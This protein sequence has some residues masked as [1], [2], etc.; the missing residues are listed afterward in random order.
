M[1]DRIMEMERLIGEI[2]SHNYSYYTLDNPT[3]SDAEYDRLY[4]RLTE[5]ERDTG[6]VLPNSPTQRVGGDIVEKFKKHKHLS[7]LLSLDKCQSYE[8]LRSWDTRL[9]KLIDSCNAELGENIDYP[10][11]IVEYKFDGLT[12]NLTYENGELVQGATRGNG[13]VG[14][15]ILPQV[16]TI[17]NVP[18]K[19]PY[20]G[21]LEV[22]GEGLMPLSSFEEYNRTAREPLKNARNGV[23]GALRNLDPKVTSK[24]NLIAYFYNVNYIE[25]VVFRSQ[26][27][28]MDFLTENK[29]PVNSYIESYSSIDDVVDEIERIK[30]DIKSLDILTDGIV[31]KVD[32]IRTREVLGFTNKFPRW[33]VAYKFESEEYTTVLLSV[34]WNVGR[35]GKVTPTANL[36]PVDINGITVKRA[37]LNN[38]DDIQRK[39]VK[40]GSKVWIRRSNDVIPEIMGTVDDGGDYREIAKPERCPACHSELVGDGVH[41][42]CPNSLSCKPQLV[43]RLSHFASRDAMNIEGFSEKTAEQL[44]E[45]LEL[46]EIPQIYELKYDDLIKLDRFGP[47]KA[48]NLLNA[49]EKSKDVE[50]SAFIYSLGIPNVGQKTAKELANRFKSLEDIMVAKVEE[51]LEI[52]DIGAIVAASIVEFFGDE[53][54]HD[55]ID[56]LIGEGLNIRHSEQRLEEN[57]FTGKTVVITGTLES[58]GRSELRSLVEGFGGKVTGSVSK[59]TDYVIV[60]ENPGSKREKALEIGVRTIEEDELREI[61]NLSDEIKIKKL[62]EE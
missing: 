16:K 50:L 25:G 59:K 47:K 38:W 32:E 19:I 30:D 57:V 14:E 42:F 48:E 60:G 1:E 6:V 23:A 49:I 33:A 46:K 40:I 17:R 43:S 10:S 35:S 29:F 11:Y 61:L 24:R 9:K 22:Q 37:T 13:E 39:K 26:L 3:V 20:R 58:I 15:G 52:P 5:L 21:K 18:L 12:I 45:Q 7:K 56:R 53:T 51:L 41:M 28:M 36:E 62:M 8:E 2:D 55:S 31:I 44:F 34:D 27:E 4:D 54:I